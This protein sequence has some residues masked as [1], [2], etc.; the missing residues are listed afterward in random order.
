MDPSLHL[1]NSI[2][3]LNEKNKNYNMHFHAGFYY[4]F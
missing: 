3:I 2:T 4:L 1:N